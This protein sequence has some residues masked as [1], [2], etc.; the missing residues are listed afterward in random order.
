MKQ[1]FYITRQANGAYSIYTNTGQPS[2]AD[3]TLVKFDIATNEMAENI[4][5][6]ELKGEFSYDV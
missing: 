3:E 2:M 1:Q 5:L 4:V 6:F